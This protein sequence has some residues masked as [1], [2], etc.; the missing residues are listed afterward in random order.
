M[1]NWILIKIS[2]LK[3]WLFSHWNRRRRNIDIEILWPSCKSKAKDLD[4]AR[5]VFRFHTSLDPAWSDLSD[6]Q[7][8]DIVDRLV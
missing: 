2:D 5:A 7:I 3:W 6:D 8:N 1:K 4:K